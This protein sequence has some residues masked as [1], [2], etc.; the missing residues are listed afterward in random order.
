MILY[1]VSIDKFGEVNHAPGMSSKVS[2]LSDGIPEITDCA[3]I[4]ALVTK[5]SSCCVA[6]KGGVTTIGSC[7]EIGFPSGTT[8][9]WVV[10]AQ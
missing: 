4:T 10:G 2:V 8:D 7:N 1:Y 5:V 6:R 9:G 3:V